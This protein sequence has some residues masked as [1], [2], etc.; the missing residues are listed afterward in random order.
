MGGRRETRSTSDIIF[1]YLLLLGIGF[2]FMEKL[3]PTMASEGGAEAFRALIKDIK[4]ATTTT[5]YLIRKCLS[6]HG[7][8]HCRIGPI[9]PRHAQYGRF[10]D[11]KSI[12][13]MVLMDI[14]GD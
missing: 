3:R 11:V 7:L 13:Q 4:F 2:H 6:Q 5:K 12:N 9:K 1:L 8:P 14:Q 10:S